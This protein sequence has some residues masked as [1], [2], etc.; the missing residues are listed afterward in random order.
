MSKKKFTV[1]EIWEANIVA[2]KNGKKLP[3]IKKKHAAAKGC[4]A[5][6]QA[7]WNLALPKA[8]QYTITRNLGKR[9]SSTTKTKPT[10]LS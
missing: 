6:A 4:T 1:D 9:K 10:V 5:E 2:S 3:H 7:L 8:E